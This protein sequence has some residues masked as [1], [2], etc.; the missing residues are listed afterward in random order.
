LGWSSEREREKTT[1][2]SRK[3]KKKNNKK[4]YFNGIRKS[5]VVC[6]CIRKQK[7]VLIPKLIKNSWKAVVST[8]TYYKVQYAAYY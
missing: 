7:V 5:I 3:K 8:L 1:E 2:T 4:F 6:I